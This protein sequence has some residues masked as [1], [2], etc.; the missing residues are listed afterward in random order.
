MTLLKPLLLATAC[1]LPALQS[2]LAARADFGKLAAN[3]DAWFKGAAGQSA[4]SNVLSWQSAQGSWPKNQ[5][6]SRST[7]QRE[8]TKIAGTF[9]NGATTGELR[10]LARAFSAT[11]DSRCRT[12]VLKGLDHI[13]AAQYPTGG[14]PQ[15]FPPGKQYHRH[16]TFNDGSTVRLLEF[17]R[18]VADAPQFA[19]VAAPRRQ[20]ARA[21]FDRG[22]QCILRCQVMVDGKPTAWCAQ[23]DEVDFSPRPGRA[24]ELVSLSGS[25]SAGILAL[26]MSL[27]N[28]APA[29][30]RAIEGGAAW[31]AAAKLTGL[32]VTKVNG[33]RVVVTDPS[34]A[35]LWA[36]FYDIGS[37]RP[38][39]C[40]RDG[41]RK[42]T[43]AEIE[44]ERRNG[45]AWYGNWGEG[46]ARQ[47]A[48]WQRRQAAR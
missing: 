29:V 22:I 4:I 12:T 25:E 15:Y 7:S 10:F 8:P 19:F 20:A 17:L 24:Y 41:V 40:G 5:D 43:L 35:S 26:L 46:V 37:N 33:D 45:Y 13:L 14:W 42:T 44:R 21:A 1:L 27:E 31:F 3:D 30:V 36:R 47:F 28:P 2:A 11:G 16:I 23:H 6:T 9:D 38:I 32:R 48:A 39:F 18:E 34:A